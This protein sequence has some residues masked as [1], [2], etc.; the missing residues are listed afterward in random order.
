MYAEMSVFQRMHATWCRKPIYLPENNAIL[1]KRTVE[2]HLFIVLQTHFKR[3][4]SGIIYYYNVSYARH[5]A[6]SKPNS[7][8]KSL[9]GNGWVVLY[10]SVWI[11][12]SI[13]LFFIQKIILVCDFPMWK[14]ALISNIID[15]LRFVECIVFHRSTN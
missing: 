9:F 13:K 1:A 7:W 5:V 12:R 4:S 3:I 2:I 11:F 10:D 14:Y 15:I 8:K 6:S